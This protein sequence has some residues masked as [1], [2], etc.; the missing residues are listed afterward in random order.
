MKGKAQIIFKDIRDGSEKIIHE[1]N[2]FTA[3]LDSLYNGNPGGVVSPTVQGTGSKMNIANPG[4]YEAYNAQSL[5]IALGGVL[6]FPQQLEENRNNLYA[7]ANNYPTG[8]ASDD[9]TDG[10]DIRRGSFQAAESGYVTRGYK[11]VWDFATSAAN[12]TWAALALTHAWGGK[13]YLREKSGYMNGA[14]MN[15]VSQLGQHGRHYVEIAGR[16]LFIA[17]TGEWI[18]WSNGTEVRK[19]RWPISKLILNP[20]ISAS[21]F[22]TASEKV[23]DLPWTSAAYIPDTDEAFFIVRRSSTTALQWNRYSISGDLLGSGTWTVSGTTLLSRAGVFAK[24]GDYIYWPK[25]DST[26]WVKINTANTADTT[27]IDLPF[28]AGQRDIHATAINDTVHTQNGIIIGNSAMVSTDAAYPRQRLQGVWLVGANYT[29][30]NTGTVAELSATPFT[31]YLATINNLQT[32]VVKDAGK[33]AKIIYTVTE[34]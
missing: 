4:I 17:I 34:E 16:N 11:F 12:G 5:R 14:T 23:V 29:T 33:T 20:T 9:G 6:V 18:I 13:S 27:E 8:Y 10:S 32:P 28:V 24:V 7:P 30:S 15:N 31:P 2:M 1:E 3:A 25:A 26:K 19:T 21:E 22:V